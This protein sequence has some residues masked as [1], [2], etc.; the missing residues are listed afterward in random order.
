MTNSGPTEPTTAAIPP[1]SRYAERNSSGKK[2]PM[3]SAPSTA[4][5]PHQMPRGSTRARASSTSPAGRARSTAVNSGRS[6]GRNS[7]VTA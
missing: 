7:V 4:A 6:G 5:L 2:A 1:G 3:L